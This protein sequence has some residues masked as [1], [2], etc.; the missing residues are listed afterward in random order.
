MFKQIPGPYSFDEILDGLGDLG[1][2]TGENDQNS[3][4]TTEN[5][6]DI[7]AKPNDPTSISAT[8]SLIVW[9]KSAILKSVPIPSR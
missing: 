5:T 2:L 8:D 9:L 3:Q 4:Q 1:N 7:R 6:G